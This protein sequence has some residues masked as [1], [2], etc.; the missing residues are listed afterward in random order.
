MHPNP[1]F[2]HLTEAEALDMAYARGFGQLSVNGEAGPIAAHIPFELGVGEVH[3]HMA[4]S[5]PIARAALPMPALL[6][7]TG[8][9]AYIS[10]DWYDTADQVPT[11]NYTA[12]HL[13][14]LL[15]PLPLDALRPHLE[16]MSAIFEARLAPKTPWKTAK[17]TDDALA[18]MMRM[19]LPFRLVLRSV[20]ATVKLGQ[21]KS[22]TA[23][24]GA[25]AGIKATPVGMEAAQ[26][27]A[28][29]RAV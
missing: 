18:R 24:A 15:V 16:R 4:R 23:R 27:A 22:A 21:N 5:N 28:M 6:A 20:E 10:P 13:R 7:V 3:L 19:I 29:M 26:I 11:W 25:A 2:R 8:P 14:G 17:M 9:D 1:A 12:V